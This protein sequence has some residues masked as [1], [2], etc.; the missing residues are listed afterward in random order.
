RSS[1]FRHGG[2]GRGKSFRLEVRSVCGT[3]NLWASWDEGHLLLSRRI[4]QSTDRNV[5][6]QD[7]GQGTRET[8]QSKFHERRLLLRRRR[9]LYHGRRLFAVWTNAAQWWPAQR[10]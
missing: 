10:K 3:A 5:V 6:F 8:E 2:A 1:R 4:L 9:S 7:S